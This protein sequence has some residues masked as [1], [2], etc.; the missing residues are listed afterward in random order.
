LFLE[1]YMTEKAMICAFMS[2][3]YD[4]LPTLGEKYLDVA[5]AHAQKLQRKLKLDVVPKVV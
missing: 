2:I 5:F 4:Q 1:Y 3:L